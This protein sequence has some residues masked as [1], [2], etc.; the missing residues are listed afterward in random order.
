VAFFDGQTAAGPPMK[1]MNRRSHETPTRRVRLPRCGCLSGAVLDA[2]ADFFR[3]DKVAVTIVSGRTL[4]G[5]PIPPRHFDRFSRVL[6]EIVDARVWGGI[7]FRTAAVQGAEIG[8]K[9]ARWLHNHYFQRAKRQGSFYEGRRLSLCLPTT[10]QTAVAASSPSV[11]SRCGDE[12]SKEIESPGS[13]WYSSK[14][15]RTP[16]RPLIT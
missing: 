16:S 14:P 15:I 2:F 6:K 3:T 10:T 4:D 8:K 7:H 12:E 13:S 9:V 5:A 1:P 11:H